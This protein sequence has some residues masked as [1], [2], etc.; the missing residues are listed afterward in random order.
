LRVRDDISRLTDLVNRVRSVREQ[1]Q[2]RAKALEARKA[3]GG[4]ADLL[5]NSDVV[6]KKADALEARL[7]NPTA[8]IV[9]DILAMR[10]GT[11]LYSRLSP[12]QM[13]AI[14]AEGPPTAGMRQ[15]LEAQEKELDALARETDEFLKRDVAPLN[16]LAAKLAMPFV[17]V[18]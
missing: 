5:K 15:V 3:E 17:I 14:E 4:V 16:D 8:E 11:K 1:L 18:R 13:W 9:Y 7:H 10:G 2:S 12:L 6:V